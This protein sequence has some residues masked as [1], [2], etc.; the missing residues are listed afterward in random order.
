M[1]PY[2]TYKNSTVR[3]ISWICETADNHGSPTTFSIPTVSRAFIPTEEIRRQAQ[4]LATL[5]QDTLVMSH[6]IWKHY[7]IM[8]AGR[9]QYLARYADDMNAAEANAG[10]AHF[11]RIMIEIQN[12][13]RDRVSVQVVAKAT[14]AKNPVILGT[15]G[16]LYNALEV[17]DTNEEIA[18]PDDVSEDSIASSTGLSYMPDT[19]DLEHDLMAK[20]GHFI[21]SYEPLLKYLDKRLSDTEYLDQPLFEHLE[22]QTSNTEYLDYWWYPVQDDTFQNYNYSSLDPAVAAFL[23]EVAVTILSDQ[24]EDIYKTRDALSERTGIYYFLPFTKNP[25]DTGYFLSLTLGDLT[26]LRKIHGQSYLLPFKPLDTRHP[27]IQYPTGI[28]RLTRRD[29]DAAL[30]CFVMDLNLECQSHEEFCKTKPLPPTSQDVISQV[31]QKVNEVTD[32]AAADRVLVQTTFCASL[33]QF[34][35]RTN[36]LQSYCELLEACNHWEDLAAG[37]RRRVEMNSLC[38]DLLGKLEATVSWVREWPVPFLQEKELVKITQD[39]EKQRQLEGMIS[40]RNHA[41]MLRRANLTLC[42]KLRLLLLVLGEEFGLELLNSARYVQPMCYLYKTI[43]AHNL[44]ARNGFGYSH[45][46]LKVT[47]ALDMRAME[48]ICRQHK[49]DLFAGEFPSKPDRIVKLMKLK[50]G[51]PLTQMA[52]PAPGRTPQSQLTSVTWNLQPHPTV[53][54]FRDYFHER[55]TMLETIGTFDKAIQEDEPKKYKRKSLLNEQGIIPFLKKL[56][57]KL[58]EAIEW[59]QPDY[60]TAHCAFIALFKKIHITMRIKGISL[61]ETFLGITEPALGDWKKG[62]PSAYGYAYCIANSV[63]QELELALHLEALM[64]KD[65]MKKDNILTPLLDVAVAVIK[66]YCEAGGD[67]FAD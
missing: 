3:V 22:E 47:P 38:E 1:V 59:M 61:H 15:L 30:A 7:K 4:H 57:P 31:L 10:H 58:K 53:S 52:H 19:F 25:S 63:V 39:P 43:M 26:A 28:E 45:V 24:E 20:W 11:L 56:E 18:F 36:P 14:T 12:L 2:K 35:I 51:R 37:V 49:K 8:L 55:R 65:K 67:G 21:S 29:R 40:F 23:A 54:I 42:G 64:G 6:V 27:S 33:L 16:S 60:V 34:P 46:Q 13:L 9:T 44:F 32:Q 62:T 50:T 5:Q 17:E 66:E 48:L 41:L